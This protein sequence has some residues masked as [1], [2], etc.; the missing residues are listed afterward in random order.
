MRNLTLF[1]IVF[2][3]VLISCSENDD[4][5]EINVTTQE[6]KLSQQEIDDLKF[7]REEEKLARDVYLFSFDKYEDPIFSGISQSEQ[8][9]MDNVLTLLNEYEIADPA[10]TER[11]VFTDELLQNLYDSLIAQSDQSLVDALIVGAIIEDLDIKDLKELRLTS[12]KDDIIEVCEILE[13]GSRNHMR[14]F[15]NQLELNN[16]LY[17]PI[18]ISLEEYNEIIS[19][20]FEF[21][22][23]YYNYPIT[24]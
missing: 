7:L 23:A 4:I 2:F 5:D 16:T 8:L 22:G 6:T 18:Y 17:T 10:S 1:T 12:N 19:S 20:P 21:C 9:H 24:Q 11:G 15:T 13:C 3:F 14:N